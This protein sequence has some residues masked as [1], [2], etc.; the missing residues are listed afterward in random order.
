[1]KDYRLYKFSTIN[2]NFID[3]LVKGYLFFANPKKLNDPF[4]CRINVRN[5]INNAM[6]TACQRHSQFGLDRLQILINHGEIFEQI[7]KDINKWGVCSFSQSI[8]LDKEPL[9]WSHYADNHCGV[10]IS[11]EIP[12]NFISERVGVIN[13]LVVSSV[14]YDIDPLSKWFIEFANDENEIDEKFADKT[15][16]EIIKVISTSKNDCWD[17]EKEEQSGT[18]HD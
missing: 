11:Y 1:M 17:Y 12:I 7:E 18:D 9:M 15:V 10:R 5:A 4:D 2:K 3:S 6:K 16:H 8:G 14:N 13:I